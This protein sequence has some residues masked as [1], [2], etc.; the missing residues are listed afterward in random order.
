MILRP[1][2]LRLWP[3]Y[4][5]ELQSPKIS[6]AQL[7]NCSLPPLSSN[8][9]FKLY[10]RA[11]AGWKQ[12]LNI[13][14][15]WNVLQVYFLLE[16]AGRIILLRKWSSQDV[17]IS[18]QPL[19]LQ[20]RRKGTASEGSR[21]DVGITGFLRKSCWHSFLFIFVSYQVSS[22]CVIL[23][24]WQQLYRMSNSYL[25]SGILFLPYISM[26]IYNLMLQHIS[27]WNG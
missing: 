14:L 1:T 13:M 19:L 17:N 16:E 11:H 9:I 27:Y 15:C 24:A 5:V 10:S 8:F 26:E 7:T 21:L 20:F 3:V 25:L 12:I 2:T 23:T 6:L 18:G 4:S 22:Q